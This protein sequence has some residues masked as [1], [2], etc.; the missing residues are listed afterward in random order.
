[1]TAL[2]R[3]Q[4]IQIF[5]NAKRHSSFHRRIYINEAGDTVNNFISSAA[6]V[7]WGIPMLVFYLSAALMFTVKSGLFQITGI[8]R[9]M[10]GTLARLFKPGAKKSSKNGISRFGAFC[11]VL[12]ACI[13]TGN[14]VGVASAI[15]SAG[16]GAVFWMCLSAF[17]GMATSYAENMLGIRYRRT[18]SGKVKGGAFAYMEYG[19][20]MPLLAKAYAALCLFS[21][22]GSGNMTQANSVSESLYTGFGIP[23]AATGLAAA[24]VC[25]IIIKGGVKR[26]AKINEYAVPAMSAVFLALS[27]WVLVKNRSSLLPCCAGIMTKAFAPKNENGFSARTAMRYG[28]ARGVFSNEAG[29]GSSTI[30]HA[31]DE[32]STETDQGYLGAFEV[33]TDTIFLCT[34]TALCILVSGEW[35][36]GSALF[37]AELSVAAYA[38]VG[39]A[40][41]KG[42]A[43]LTAVFGFAS[44]VGWSFYGEKSGEALF[45]EKISGIYKYLYCAVSFIGCICSPKIIWSLSDI[46][47][48][49]MAV[50]NLFSII[51]L[52]NEVVW[53]NKIRSEGVSSRRLFR[54]A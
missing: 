42:I 2:Y 31:E 49:L 33:F 4:S 5:E 17:L 22:L 34:L 16:A 41:K 14:I 13:G 9:W 54:R 8:N 30:I 44:L 53:E 29:I 50:P 39:E 19:V 10:G 7:V 27:L 12:A 48:G 1:M 26:I 28:I 43:L 25:L 51:I 35:S 32:A 21:S 47:S 52:R 38:V 3:G 23:K 45:G 24:A 15:A 46:T 20:K 18:V 11:S 36:E 40:G 6:N 37:G